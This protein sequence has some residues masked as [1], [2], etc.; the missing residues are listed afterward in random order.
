MPHYNRWVVGGLIASFSGIGFI[1]DACV[2]G[3]DRM[4]DTL[5][6]QARQLCSGDVYANEPRALAYSEGIRALDAKIEREKLVGEER[7]G[8][9]GLIGAGLLISGGVLALGGMIKQQRYDFN[10]PS[11]R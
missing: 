11:Y 4:R 2:P 9:L 3:S 10:H 1:R 5:Q 6:N 8:L 7:G